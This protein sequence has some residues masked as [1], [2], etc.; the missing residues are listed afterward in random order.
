MKLFEFLKM[1]KEGL[2]IKL[3][4]AFAVPILTIISWLAVG[5]WSKSVEDLEEKEK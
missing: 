4:A 5:Y 1:K 3:F 2:T